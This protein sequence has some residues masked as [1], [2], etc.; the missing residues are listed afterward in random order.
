MQRNP[1][2]RT[3]VGNRNRAKEGTVPTTLHDW[4]RSLVP[5]NHFVQSTLKRML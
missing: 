4:S 1:C 3:H 5:K 2:A